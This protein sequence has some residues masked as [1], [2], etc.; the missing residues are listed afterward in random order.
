MDVSVMINNTK[1]NYR[2]ATLIKNN[3]KILLHKSK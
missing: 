2:V 3:N 1:F